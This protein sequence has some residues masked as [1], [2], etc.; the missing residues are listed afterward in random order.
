M[1]RSLTGDGVAPMGDKS[2]PIRYY[3]GKCG[4]GFACGSNNKL[5]CDW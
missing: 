2:T 5:P 3:A 4:P 1:A